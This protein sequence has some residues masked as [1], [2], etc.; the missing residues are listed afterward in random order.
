MALLP[1]AQLRPTNHQLPDTIPKWKPKLTTGSKN[2]SKNWE[3]IQAMPRDRLERTVVLNEVRQI[4]RQQRMLNGMMQHINTNPDLKQLTTFWSRTCPKTSARKSCLK[5]E[6]EK[7]LNKK[8]H[9][10]RKL[11]PKPEGKGSGFELSFK[12]RSGF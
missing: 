6:R 5:M 3:Y 12:A 4:E 7:R 8:N 10:S 9:H 11:K 1:P 2:N